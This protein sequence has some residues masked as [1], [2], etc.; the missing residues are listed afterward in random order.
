VLREGG[1]PAF[2]EFM[3]GH[4][5][6]AA[7]GTVFRYNTGETDLLGI[8]LKNAT[9]QDLSTYLSQKVWSQFAMEADAFW[10]V[11]TDGLE[12]AACCLSATLRDFGRFG[13]FAMRGGTLA[14][15]TRIV[16]DDWLQRSI[17]ASPA[18]ADYGYL[19]WLFPTNNFAAIGVF[20]Q[21]IHLF[22]QDE[23]V[24]VMQSFWPA[25]GGPEYA[26]HRS[27]FL[28]ALRVTLTQ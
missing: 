25:D 18:S 20:G 15:G 14:D 8:L 9:H 13:I 23:L 17:T 4:P 1:I 3:T 11:T 12:V 2:T 22:P 28:S 19:W 27:A 24:V 5:R 26:A 10:V 6:V 7:P 16:P 21:S